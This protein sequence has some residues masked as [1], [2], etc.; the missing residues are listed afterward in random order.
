LP[1]NGERETTLSNPIQV[2]N[3]FINRTGGIAST[4]VNAECNAGLLLANSNVIK[5]IVA[6]PL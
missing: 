4:F 6:N 1:R 3:A 2:T 5:A